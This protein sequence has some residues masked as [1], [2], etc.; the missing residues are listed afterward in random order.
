MVA[1]A[2]Q[3]SEEFYTPQEYLEIERQA[4]YK[5]EFIHG[6]IYAMAGASTAHNRLT[7]NLIISL[8]SQLR[9]RSCEAMTSDMRVRVSAAGDYTYP[10]VLVVCDPR[11]DDQHQDSLLNPVVIV[12]VL[13]PST[14]A[15][16]RGDK[17]VLYRE[18]PSLRDYILVEQNRISVEHFSRQQDGSWQL[19]VYQASEDVVTLT[20][21][22][23]ILRV[24]EMYER[25]SF[26]TPAPA[27]SD[28]LAASAT[29][30]TS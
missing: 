19:R 26:E 5:S 29:D 2:Y 4:K 12:E 30:T 23:C 7:A 24:A 3:P 14:A 18:I 25:V 1:Q 16:D 28:D 10:D 9:G 6:Q 27:P 22:D 20:S 8:G 21:I 17:W 15:F 11:F 13:S